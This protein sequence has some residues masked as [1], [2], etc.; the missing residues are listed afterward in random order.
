MSAISIPDESE[1]AS[2]SWR[3]GDFALANSLLSG[4]D[5][6]TALV[7]GDRTQHMYDRF[8]DIVQSVIRETIPLTTNRPQHSAYIRRLLSIQSRLYSNNDPTY[9]TFSKKVGVAIR[10]EAI[11]NEGKRILTSNG[12]LFSHM[13]SISKQKAAVSALRNSDVDNGLTPPFSSRTTSTIETLD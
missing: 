8:V 6:L 5:W 4:I 11:R 1:S 2:R 10:S 12:G 7:N 13:R 3:K 9:E